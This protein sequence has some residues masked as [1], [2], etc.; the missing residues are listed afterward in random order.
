VSVTSFTVACERDYTQGTQREADFIDCVAWRQ[1]GEFVS[2][3]FRKGSMIVVDGRLQSRKWQDRDGNKR[4][5]W[6]V[7]AEHCYF[8]ESRR[9]E[10]STQGYQPP[11]RAPVNVDPP[12]TFDGFHDMPAGTGADNP[13]AGANAGYQQAVMWDDVNGELPF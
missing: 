10:D 3:Y 13:F 11:P 1:T 8:G 9:Q 12:Q 2:K 6:E 7:N 5:A 4:V